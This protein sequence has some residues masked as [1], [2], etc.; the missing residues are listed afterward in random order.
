MFY[1]HHLA[2]LSCVGVVLMSSLSLTVISLSCH[3]GGLIFLSRPNGSVIALLNSKLHL[4]SWLSKS[5]KGSCV[6]MFCGR[7]ANY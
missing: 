4:P 1:I 3:W 2:P 6:V 5:S 7:M